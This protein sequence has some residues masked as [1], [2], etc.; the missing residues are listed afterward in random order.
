MSASHSPIQKCC[1]EFGK[2][3]SNAA[4]ALMR[5]QTREGRPNGRFCFNIHKHVRSPGKLRRSFHVPQL[6]FYANSQRAAAES[7]R[8][9]TQTQRK[10]APSA[11]M[12]LPLAAK[13]QGTRSACSC[14]GVFCFITPDG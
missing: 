4:S 5:P 8:E 2:A 6:F 10:M 3:A 14:S 9:E 7:K 13:A 1:E 11:R 12:R